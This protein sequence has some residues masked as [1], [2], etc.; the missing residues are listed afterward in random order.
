SHHSLVQSTPPT[1][2]EVIPL[3]Q[4]APSKTDTERLLVV[5]PELADVLAA[6]I[7]R[8]RQPSGAVACVASYDP[9]E[10]IWNPAM[11][12]LFQPQ[13]GMET[14]AIPSCTIR[15]WICE[16]MPDTSPADTGQADRPL[17]TRQQRRLD[18][19]RRHLQ[20]PPTTHRPA[21]Q[22]RSHGSPLRG[23]RTAAISDSPRNGLP[24]G[25]HQRPS[26]VHRPTTS[27]TT[28]R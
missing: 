16:S 2:T 26:R 1:S 14:R 10:R 12:L 5:S 18:R 4:I 28:Q 8:I 25:S 11:P 23:I 7:H 27:P 15:D 22:T 3:L 9:H 6:V 13:L 24:R 17:A 20:P 21:H 19:I